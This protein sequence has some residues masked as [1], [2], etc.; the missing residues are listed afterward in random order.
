MLKIRNHVNEESSI[1]G[2]IVRAVRWVDCVV[3]P[4]PIVARRGIFAKTHAAISEAA[5]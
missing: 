2:S 5:R 4:L 3:T 1:V